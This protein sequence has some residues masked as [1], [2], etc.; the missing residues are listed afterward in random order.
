V[1][2]IL[3]SLFI[4]SKVYILYFFKRW[5]SVFLRQ[6]S[7]NSLALASQ[8]NGTTGVH[9]LPWLSVYF[10]QYISILNGLFYIPQHY[11][12]CFCTA[13]CFAKQYTLSLL[14]DTVSDAS[15][16]L[17]KF[18]DYL[19]QNINQSMYSGRCQNYENYIRIYIFKEIIAHSQVL[20][21]F[22]YLP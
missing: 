19:M 18:W 20:G 8:I 10:K 5:D 22:T 11:F 7:R 21:N 15:F 17:G 12:L 16:L 9:L 3:I 6:A 14:T 13:L 2:E 4:V 1:W